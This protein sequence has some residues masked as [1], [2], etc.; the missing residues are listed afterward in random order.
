[1]TD[2][3]GSQSYCWCK[4][5]NTVAKAAG[6]SSVM[7]ISNG[8]EVVDPGNPRLSLVASVARNTGDAKLRTYE[9]TRN[10]VFP[11]EHGRTRMQSPLGSMST[12]ALAVLTAE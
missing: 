7:V 3:S 9:D 8:R 10:R 11:R 1:M 12:R 6:S 4:I 2:N 5:R